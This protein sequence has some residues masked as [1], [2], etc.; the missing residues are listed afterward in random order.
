MLGDKVLSLEAISIQPKNGKTAD[1]LLIM[2]HGWGAN[3]EDLAPLASTLNLSNY[4]YLFPNAPFP[5]PQVPW[6]RAWYALDSNNYQGLNESR[7]LLRDWL[8]SLP[9]KT[10][11]ELEN[12]VLA[13]FSQGGAMTLDV[14]LQ[15]PLA[16]LCSLSGYL[17]SH[18]APNLAEYPLLAIIHGKQDPIVPLKAAQMA[19]DELMAAGVK[20]QYNELGMGHEINAETIVI[21]RDFILNVGDNLAAS[22][23]R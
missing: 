20:L 13:G 9:K 8:Q 12:T 14:G 19:R 16:G 21:L 6:G 22:G 3:A 11:I 7:Q 5:H 15:L 10:G 1:R 4:Q 2:L 23:H 18:P 17:H